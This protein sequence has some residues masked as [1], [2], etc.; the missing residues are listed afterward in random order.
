ME[1]TFV[2]TR[3]NIPL[4]NRRHRRHSVLK[5]SMTGASVLIDCGSDWLSR[6]AR[7]SPTA[8]VLTHAH[9]DHIGGLI[10]GAPCPVYAPADVWATMPRLDLMEG[11]DPARAYSDR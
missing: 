11:N 3:A 2:G 6:L 4:R 5:I 1:L 10:H 7:L 9:P 8:I